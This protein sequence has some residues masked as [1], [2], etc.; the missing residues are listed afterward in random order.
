MGVNFKIYF[1]KVEYECA[2]WVNLANDSDNLLS[3]MNTVMNIWL[4]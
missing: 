2:D 4:P 3:F 1:T